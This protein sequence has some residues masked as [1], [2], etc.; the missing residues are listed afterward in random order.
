M[1]PAGDSPICKNPGFLPL[2]GMTAKIRGDNRK[3]LRGPVR[4]YRGLLFHSVTV[5]L[6]NHRPMVRAPC[7]ELRKSRKQ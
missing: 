4:A 3:A 2:V 5:N 7:G 6:P 1:L